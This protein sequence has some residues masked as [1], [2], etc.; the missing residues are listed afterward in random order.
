MQNITET[1]RIPL[2]SEKLIGVVPE[3]S[4]QEYFDIKSTKCDYPKHCYLRIN[5][6]TNLE[7][8]FPIS[9]IYDVQP[10]NTDTAVIYAA[11]ILVFL[12]IL[13]IFELVHKT[14]AAII[15]STMSL[16]VLAALNARPTIGEIIS[17][18]DIETLLLLFSMMTLV[19]IFGETGIFDYLAVVAYKVFFAFF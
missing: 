19:A 6:E 1:R 7:T 12:Y 4:V 16:A 15:A 8:N 10:I 5:L 9:L 11:T 13:I 17:W 18:I 14:L 3:I 2:V